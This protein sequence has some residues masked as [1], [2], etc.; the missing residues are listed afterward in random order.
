MPLSALL[1]GACPGMAATFDMAW[2]QVVD[3]FLPIELTVDQLPGRVVAGER[4]LE[5]QYRPVLHGEELEQM[6]V[7]LTDITEQVAF[8]A[9]EARQRDLLAALG[10]A[11][12]NRRLFLE[13]LDE[14]TRLVDGLEAGGEPDTVE[15]RRLHT[16]KGNTVTYGMAGFSSLCHE[17]EDRVED[18]CGAIL[19]PDR[20][21]LGASWRALRAE[22]ERFVCAERAEV[23][24]LPS[25]LYERHLTR[26]QQR[27]DHRELALDAQLWM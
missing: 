1:E 12:D 27:V 6:V 7:I 23:V 5:I 15:R 26:I 14:T 2:E 25:A 4:T 24:E 20:G 9:F 17:V 18:N 22:I 19:A 10:K 21:L 16:I 11:S 3:G 8:E 13:F